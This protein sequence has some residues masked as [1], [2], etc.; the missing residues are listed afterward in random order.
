MRARGGSAKLPPVSVPTTLDE[1]LKAFA[2]DRQWETYRVVIE[3]GG[4]RAAARIL[5]LT[6]TTVKGN[7]FALFRRAAQSGYA[8]AHDLTHPLP[9]GLVSKGTSVLYGQDGEVERVWNKSRME[10]LD[11]ETRVQLPDPKTIT[12]VSTLYDQQGRVTQQWVAEKPEAVQQQLAW[13]EAAQALA[14]TLPRVPEIPAPEGSHSDVMACF[15][16]GDHHLGMLSWPEETGGAWDVKLAESLLSAATDHLVSVCPQSEQALIAFLGDFLHFDGFAAVTP[17]SRNLL[18]ADTR[19]PKMVRAAIRSMRHMIETAAR[20]Y[21]KVHVIVEIGNHD[22]SSSIFL[23]EA[24]ANIYED[25]PRITIDTSPR[26]FHYF[27]FGKT[28]IGTHHGHEAKAE[29]L[30]SIMA[31]DMPQA[32][33][34]TEHRYFWTG[35]IHHQSVKDFEKVTV[36]SFRILAPADAWAS[37]KGFR[38]R[39]EMKAIVVHKEFGEVARHSVTP[40]M[41]K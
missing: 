33:G 1:G 15:P 36:E 26:F 41:F 8:P 7:V 39:R 32:W 4:Y 13:L 2:T 35:H 14:E 5:G 38:S 30:P 19:F 10:G 29:R 34:R 16:V 22:L 11:P 37:Q 3:Q 31:A 25:N 17:T 20:K 18:D 6:R 28:L 27:E 21:Q 40:E 24:L 9:E 23:M 12:K